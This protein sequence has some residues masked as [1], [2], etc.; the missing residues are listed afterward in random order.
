MLNGLQ[1]RN[2]L[3]TGRQ[4]RDIV[5]KNF[6]LGFFKPK[7]DLCNL[8][9][10][11]RNKHNPRE[12]REKYKSAYV[13]HRQNNKIS[14]KM[15]R[16]DILTAIKDETIAVVSFDLQ[17]QL[18]CPKSEASSFFYRNKLTV[19][20]FTTFN[21]VKRIGN[22]Y[23]WHEGVAKKGSDEISSCLFFC[24]QDLVNAGYKEVRFYSDNCSGQNKNRFVFGM[25]VYAAV[26]FGIKITHTFLEPGHTLMEV[27]SIHA[28]I[29]TSTKDKDIYCFDDWVI[30]IQSAKEELPKYQVQVLDRRFVYSFKPLVKL[31]NWEK[32]L[33]GAPIQWR[34]V[35][36]V[37]VHG[38]ENNL[39]RLKYEYDGQFTTMSPN[40]RVG[41]PVNLKS[42]KPPLAYQDTIPLSKKTAEH[43]QWYIDTNA[44]PVQKQEFF[45][46][47]L[48]GIDPAD[49][50]VFTEPEYE[51]DEEMCVD[52]PDAV[53]CR[54]RKNGSDEEGPEEDVGDKS[55]EEDDERESLV[56]DNEQGNESEGDEE[57]D[58]DYVPF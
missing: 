43:L 50:E 55:A 29:E 12:I 52:N 38:A 51:T 53:L 25:F 10:I 8:C 17:K 57:N 54:S 23:L 48:A 11:I 45:R 28:R 34:K 27:D 33:T 16:D 47:V 30:A 6:N 46:K 2:C 14:Q 41:R 20:N 15:K 1:I 56:H 49:E 32:D 24:I 13:K 36:Q 44:I 40:S 58:S 22:C 7:K 4:Y 26:L 9:A 3:A 31:Q 37:V 18:N 42:Y 35:K 39:V 19:F 5:N 21:S